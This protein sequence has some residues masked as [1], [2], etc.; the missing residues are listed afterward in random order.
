MK[1]I[2]STWS[3]FAQSSL[4]GI[5]T[6]YPIINQIYLFHKDHNQSLANIDWT[7]VGW[8]N[9][10]IN[11][12]LTID[13]FLNV[14][15]RLST[16][17][18]PKEAQTMIKIILIHSY[19]F[20]KIYFKNYANWSWGIMFMPESE[21]ILNLEGFKKFIKI[22]IEM[23][24]VDRRLINFKEIIEMWDYYSNQFNLIFYDNFNIDEQ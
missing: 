9:N 22:I 2:L 6:F 12:F 15:I 23:K 16:S 5:S 24:L 18:L 21:L 19:L 17:K 1:K 10:S 20:K 4:N 7:I 8:L 11:S 13:S 14:S 3:S